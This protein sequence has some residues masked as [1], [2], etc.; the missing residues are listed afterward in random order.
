MISL[1]SLSAMEVVLGIDN[2]V[3]LSILSNKLPP[4][5][6]TMARRI[7]LTLALVLR[8]GLLTTISV[9]MRFTTPLF[10]IGSLGVTGRDLILF[11][12]GMFLILK[13]GQ[14]LYEKVLASHDDDD[15]VPEASVKG[16]SY[17]LILGQIAFFDLVFS[18][19]SIITAVGMTDQL[20]VMI[21]ATLFAVLTMMLFA[22]KVGNFI[23]DHPSVK[24]LA[25]AFLVLVGGVL[26]TESLHVHMSHTPIYAAMGF[27]LLVELLC[28]KYRQ[29][30][31]IPDSQAATQALREQAPQDQADK[32]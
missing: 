30:K 7:G 26:V 4:S 16:G 11:A 31:G 3:F 28:M 8:V 1:I 32:A 25:L 10:H 20:P 12:G 27:S 17:A 24:I 13:S 6:R 14:E 15:D 29:T 21:G 19:D 22:D 9:I 5:Q 18:L 23:A 2:I